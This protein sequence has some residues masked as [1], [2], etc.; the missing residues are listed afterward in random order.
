MN[1]SITF[2]I[3]TWN[4]EKEISE[5]LKTVSKYSPDTSKIIVVDNNS[6]DSTTTIIEEQFPEVTLI[7][8]DEN[9]GFAKGNNIALNATTTEYVCFL[10]PD[11]ILTQDIVT[12]SI[13]MLKTND[14]IGL[15]SCRLNN[16]DGSWQPST[17]SFANS[18]NLY[19]EIL[20]I[21]EF[22]PQNI[23]KKRFINYYRPIENFNPDWV[24]GAEM[25]M[26]T[27]EAQKIGGFS[28]EYY[29]YTEDMDLC[30]KI[31]T[32]LHKNVLFLPNHSL[33]HL[34]GAS[35]SQ[36][37]NYNKQKKLYENDLMFVKKFYGNKEAAN[38]LSSMKKAYRI[39]GKLIKLFY[40][41]Q[42]RK[43]QIT[44]NEKSIK[45]LQELTV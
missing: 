14:R 28:T 34:G 12:P 32:I 42:D 43:K 15:V 16:R 33:I 21:G 37:I 3:V 22:M 36:N 6:S 17:F 1:D 30:K 18:K 39:R 38:T 2:V 4:N 7:K 44:N 40:Y 35:E 11:V 8:S 25:I 45:I 10:N 19:Y 41:K 20:H 9:L 13:N 29:M 31:S 23:C 24:I 5:C 26:R 27:E